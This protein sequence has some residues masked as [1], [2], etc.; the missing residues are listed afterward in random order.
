MMLREMCKHIEIPSNLRD[1][2][3]S[4]IKKWWKIAH[5]RNNK[6]TQCKFQTIILVN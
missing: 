1:T 5:A 6:I 2:K 4:L 3:S